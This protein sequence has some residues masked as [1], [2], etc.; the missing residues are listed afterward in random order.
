MR[1]L[2]P[3]SHGAETISPARSPAVGS[4]S[5]PA[6]A[7]VA[8]SIVVGAC[9]GA[10]D[11]ADRVVVRDSAGIEI[12]ESP[13]GLADRPYHLR[14]GDRVADIGVVDGAAEY[15]LFRVTS[16]ASL[17]DGRIVVANGGTQELRFFDSSGAFLFATGG[18]G[19]GP[20]EYQYPL[21]VPSLHS[22][23]L[24]VFDQ[25]ASRLTVLN[26]EGELVRT[27]A[28]GRFGDPL[29][30]VSDGRMLIVR[31]T[32]R[33]GF[34]T[35]EGLMP[36][37]RVLQLMVFGDV[38]ADT[39]ARYDG[40]DLF[41]S[42]QNGRIAF[43]TVPFDVVP[44]ATVGDG[45]IFATPGRMAEVHELA[46]DGRR[47]RIMRVAREPEQITRERFD[48][49]VERRVQSVDDPAEAAE[50]RRRYGET[51]MRELVP[52]YSRILVDSEGNIWAERYREDTATPPT[53]TIFDASGE[54][55]GMLAFPAGTRLLAV[56]GSRAIAVR[57]D[58]MDVEH[59]VAWP[60]I[61]MDEG[62]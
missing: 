18:R 23:S 4:G 11:A 39:L 57:R 2:R 31:S 20:G 49:F 24:F 6:A 33:A 50:A 28:S 19:D 62:A 22:D 53:W 15:Q 34:D 51:P 13:A 7:V 17:T 52:A 48:A 37:Q 25:Q 9:G 12:I 42:N 40:P 26:L 59:V 30:V 56:D 47:L 14:L 41:M 58:E 44:N 16:V 21:I 61:P 43:T 10:G 46:P 8:I 29:G 60:L 5:V 3:I 35:P 27:V 55:A 32:A 38:T 45:R 1:S 36:N 54:A